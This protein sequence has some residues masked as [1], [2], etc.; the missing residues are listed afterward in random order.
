MYPATI[1]MEFCFTAYQARL[2]SFR[3]CLVSIL[4]KWW[5]WPEER[6][7]SAQHYFTHTDIKKFIEWANDN[8]L[9]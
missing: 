2:S 6:L 9:Y 3:R 8:A 1:E 4:M 5:D 7:R